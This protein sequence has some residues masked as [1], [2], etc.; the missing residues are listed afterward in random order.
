ML[1]K[2]IMQMFNLDPN[3]NFQRRHMLICMF[4]NTWQFLLCEN[5]G[6]SDSEH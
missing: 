1:A 4:Y 5:Y 2:N 3:Q 6:N